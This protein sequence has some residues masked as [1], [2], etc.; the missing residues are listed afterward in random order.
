MISLMLGSLSSHVQRSGSH[1][2]ELDVHVDT[3]ADQHAAGFERLVP[4][5][6]EI[7]SVDGHFGGETDPFVAPG[8][9]GPAAVLDLERHLV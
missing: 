5:Q 9:L 1:R 6:T 8:I 7:L 2:F 3:V 4:L